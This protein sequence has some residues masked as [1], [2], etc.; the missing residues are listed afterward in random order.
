MGIKRESDLR[1]AIDVIRLAHTNVYDLALIFCRDQDFSEVA[2]EVKLISKSTNRWDK[3]CVSISV[4]SSSE[5]ISRDEII[6]N[7]YLFT[8]TIR[9]LLGQERL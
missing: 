4:Q 3:G 6:R 9:Y 1:I 2:D 8:N 7:G 5:S